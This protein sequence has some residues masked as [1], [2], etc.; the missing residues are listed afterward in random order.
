MKHRTLCTGL[1][2]VFIIVMILLFLRYTSPV[3]RQDFGFEGKGT[4]ISPYQIQSVEDLEKFRDL[5]NSGEDFTNVYFRQTQNLDLADVE[6]WTPIGVYGKNRYFYG[7]YDG[8]GHTISNLV[9]I[10]DSNTGFFGLLG[11]EVRN[12]GIESGYIE[13]A[14]IGA[15]AS[16]GASASTTITNCYNKAEIHGRHR[17]GGIADN[18]SGG[19]IRYCWNLGQ[20]HADSGVNYGISSFSAVIDGCYSLNLSVAPEPVCQ[21]SNTRIFAV[22]EFENMQGGGVKYEDSRDFNIIEVDGNT[23]IFAQ[24]NNRQKLS[25][26]L[27]TNL[28]LTVLSAFS[29]F[30]CLIAMNDIGKE[31][32]SKDTGETEEREL[33]H[34]GRGV[35]EGK[36]ILRMVFF[37]LMLSGGTIL[38]NQT[39]VLKRNDGIVTMQNYYRQPKESVDV[40]FLGSSRAGVNLDLETLWK[41]YGISGYV[42]WGSRQPFWNSY[43]FLK[44][45]VHTSRPKLIVLD[46]SAAT[47][48]FVY[49]D[50][51][52]QYTNTYGIKNLLSRW[53]AVQISAPQN[54]WSDLMWGMP[55]YHSRFNELTEAD[56]SHYAWES[57]S[58]NYKGNSVRYTSREYDLE[59]VSEVTEIEKIPSKQERY[60]RKIIEYCQCEELPILLTVTPSP[61]RMKEQPYYNAVQ[62]IA[63]E[64][65]VSFINF[66]LLD[67]E[68]GFEATDFWE[69]DHINTKGGRKISRY[70][71]QYLMSNYM[72]SDHRGNANYRSWDAFADNMENDYLRQITEAD[73]YFRE[74]QRDNR[75]AL[76]I[77][78]DIPADSE[79][80][81]AFLMQTADTGL[82]LSFLAE[83]GKSCYVV[84]GTKSQEYDCTHECKVYL[85]NQGL[86]VDFAYSAKVF[87]DGE[88]VYTMPQTGVICLAYD[89]F[90][91][92]IVDIVVFSEDMQYT[93]NHQLQ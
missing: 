54:R 83:E 44:E 74:L 63:K 50:D 73:D 61:D 6:N 56:F 78:R 18:L 48:D 3:E 15:I 22:E 55:I 8:A 37:L 88:V 68:T 45:A 58:V 7:I 20:V 16:H 90:I 26:W 86:T 13:G 77:K 4:R 19:N 93:V 23:I 2:M 21:I 33:Y 28:L 59:D 52:R 49:S 46:V 10:S 14:Y 81:G 65:N 71:G 32:F 75:Q 92:E 82:D 84:D 25:Q 57:D 91:G 12:L 70:L 39:L 42:C 89:P 1:G 30:V 9:S 76:I 35:M 5:V 67:A 36:V 80:Y 24:G 38:I 53:Q 64:Y 60:L 31:K 79:A 29:I 34:V 72:L 85:G 41:E 17:A 66:N 87:A 51:S 43:Y 47:Y 27:K 11:G 40:L 69:D 62:E